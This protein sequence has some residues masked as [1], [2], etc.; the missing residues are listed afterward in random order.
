[1]QV[2]S[3]Q[4]KYP[5]IKFHIA[6]KYD[7]S[8]PDSIS[9]KEFKAI[10]DSKYIKYKGFIDIKIMRD[11]LY[12]S[13]VLVLPSYGEGLPKIALEASATGLPLILSDVRGCRDCIIDRK[14]GLLIKAQNSTD[15]KNAMEKFINQKELIN[16]YGKFSSEVVKKNFSIDIISQK[17][18]KII[19]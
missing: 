5:D 6:G 10:Q 14:N 16:I 19:D 13:S 15:L 9:E 8:N 17:F 4:K 7:P 3:L 18:L 12:K 2:K 1:M 11:C